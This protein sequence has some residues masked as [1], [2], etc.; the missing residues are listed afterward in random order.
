MT[1]Q[2][3][4][5]ETNTYRDNPR[6]FLSVAPSLTK[7]VGTAPEGDCLYASSFSLPPHLT[8]SGVDRCCTNYRFSKCPAWRVHFSPRAPN[9]ELCCFRG[10]S[11]PI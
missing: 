5:P 7:N 10:T 4:V 11:C 3:I 1:R 8:T 2:G 6:V 9:N